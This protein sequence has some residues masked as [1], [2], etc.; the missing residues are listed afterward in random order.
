M[1]YRK[2]KWNWRLIAVVVTLVLALG[3]GAV[4]L[5]AQ[6]RENKA[7]VENL[8]SWFARYDQDFREMRKEVREIW[9]TVYNGQ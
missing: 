3:G 8:E 1:S 5:A 4:A 2:D 6:V 7:D 9:K